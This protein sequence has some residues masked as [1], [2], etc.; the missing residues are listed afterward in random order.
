MADDKNAQP[1]TDDFGDR[2]ER[3]EGAAASNAFGVDGKAIVDAW[4]VVLTQATAQPRASFEAGRKLA[5]DMT[6]IWF[7]SSDVDPSE[8]DARFADEAWRENPLFRRIG[9]SYL[10]WSNS[11]DDW[12][13]ASGL[14]GIEHDRAQFVLSAAKDVLAP[15]NTLV[16]N[17]AALKKL[18]ETQGASF[19]NGMRNIFDD[20]RHNHGYPAVA[21]R[22]AFTVGVDVAA[23]EGSVVFRNELFELIQ[24]QPKTEEVSAIP[25]L[26]VFSQVNRFYL[27]DL[28]PDRSLFQRLLDGGIPVF[29][30][31]WR[32]PEKDHSQWNL[33]T[34][35]DGVIEAVRVMREVIFRGCT[36]SSGGDMAHDAALRRGDPACP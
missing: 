4:G 20:V 28:T 35:A 13:A 19:V 23:S 17:P 10:A 14:E 7:G 18:Q 1:A 27:G 9:Q 32:N 36:I 11:L 34:Y 31:S 33:D 12:L 29:A 6:R 3:T 25:L 30:I 26:Y 24:Y 15:V 2:A 22:E 21:D 16:G 5:A 8:T